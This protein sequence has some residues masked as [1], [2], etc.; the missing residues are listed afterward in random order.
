MKTGSRTI[1]ITGGATGIGFALAERFVKA[2]SRVIVCG[3]RE[4]ALLESARRV[5]GLEVLVT[6]LAREEERASLAARVIEC[7]PG[8][9]VLVNNAGIQRR[10]RFSADDAPWSER[11]QEIAINFEAPVH[12]TALLLPHLRKQAHA[13][14]S[15]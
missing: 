2:G 6:D 3:R 14:S 15:T 5:P 4:D 7:F 13:P 11:R 8:L 1:L 12:L 10:A 9:D